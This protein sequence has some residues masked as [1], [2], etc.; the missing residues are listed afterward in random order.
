MERRTAMSGEVRHGFCAMSQLIH[1]VGLNVHKESVAV[2]SLRWGD[3]P[4][5]PDCRRRRRERSE[6]LHERLQ[7]RMLAPLASLRSKVGSNGVSPHRAEKPDVGCRI[8]AARDEED[9]LKALRPRDSVPVPFQHLPRALS[10][11]SIFFR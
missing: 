10:G 5:S 4:W 8:A 9:V 7:E 1:F 2:S 11:Q 3:T 6:H